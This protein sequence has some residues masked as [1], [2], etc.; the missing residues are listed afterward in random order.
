MHTIIR[1]VCAVGVNGQMGLDGRLPWEGTSD[2]VFVD[3]AKT[4]LRIDARTRSPRW[5]Q[6]GGVDPKRSIPRSRHR[7]CQVKNAARRGN[8]S[9]S[10]SDYFYRRGICS[11]GRLCAADQS[12]GYHQVPYDGD[13]DR[14]FNSA[15][16]KLGRRGINSSSEE[17]APVVAELRD[18]HRLWAIGARELKSFFGR[19]LE[20]NLKLLLCRQQNGHPL[21]I[22]ARG[23]CVRLGRH[24]RVDSLRDGLTVFLQRPSVCPPDS[25]KANRGR[26]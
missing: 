14:W 17:V 15:W 12:L 13:A 7:R 1:S 24:E 23:Q 19:S 2:P 22:D 6:D 9:V 8:F 26:A 3:D 18:I 25:R 11:L 21:V 20:P 10:G 5:T 16:L 4:L